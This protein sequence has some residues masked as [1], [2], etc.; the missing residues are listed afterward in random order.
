MIWKKASLADLCDYRNEDN[1]RCAS[2]AQ[3]YSLTLAGYPAG[4]Y[5][6]HHKKEMAAAY[7]GALSE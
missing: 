6:Q 1:E 2:A 3:P 4:H 5:C 7:S